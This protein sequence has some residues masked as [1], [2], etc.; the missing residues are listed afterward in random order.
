MAFFENLGKKVGEAASIAAKKSGEVVEITKLSMNIAG[1]ED[2]VKTAYTEIGKRVY[3]ITNSGTE[4]KPADYQSLV[5]QISVGK[6]AI[7]ELKEK[8][9]L[10]KNLKHCTG[11]GVELEKSVAFCVKLF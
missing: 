5:E 1:E 4:V 3:E 9:L 6:E 7:K 11:C 8:I 2:K 10:V